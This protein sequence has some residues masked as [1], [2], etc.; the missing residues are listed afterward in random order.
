MGLVEGKLKEVP[1]VSKTNVLS[2]NEIPICG[3]QIGILKNEELTRT[4]S[5]AIKVVVD[6]I[7]E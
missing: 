1:T 6:K 2:K 4:K 7:V 5:G 3:V